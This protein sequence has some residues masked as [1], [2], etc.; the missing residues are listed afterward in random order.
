L[1][2]AVDVPKMPQ[3]TGQR[4]IRAMERDGWVV[5]RHGKHTQVQHTL[6]KQVIS[7][8]VHG[9]R[10]I[11]PGTLRNILDQAGMSVERLLELL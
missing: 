8:P 7:I 6:G 10:A 4:L 11:A 9:S 5:I 2:E 3:V 1:Q